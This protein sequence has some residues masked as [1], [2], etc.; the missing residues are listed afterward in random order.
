MYKQ[1]KRTNEHFHTK[2]FKGELCPR[3]CVASRT[4]FTSDLTWFRYAAFMYTF[5]GSPLHLYRQIVNL[6]V[7]ITNVI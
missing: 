1:K 4:V 7:I 6:G 3:K 5:S 2:S